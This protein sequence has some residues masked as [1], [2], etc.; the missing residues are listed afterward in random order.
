MTVTC[1]IC[2][3]QASHVA[4]GG[5]WASVGLCGK[6]FADHK[7]IIAAGDCPGC[8]ARLDLCADGCIFPMPGD[9]VPVGGA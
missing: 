1:E 6:C 8:G 7:A 5:A 9:F 4:H 2:G 3:A